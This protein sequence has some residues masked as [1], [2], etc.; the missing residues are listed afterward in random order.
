MIRVMP[1]TPSLVGSGATVF[2]R[3]SKAND[4]DAA[5]A[6]RLFSSVGICEE[7]SENMID[8]VTALAGSGP[9]YV[10]DL[11]SEALSASDVTILF[12]ANCKIQGIRNDRSPG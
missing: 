3:G 10:R 4:E 7:V 9:A 1:N 12:Y 8:P 5:L 2:A 6:S 11:I